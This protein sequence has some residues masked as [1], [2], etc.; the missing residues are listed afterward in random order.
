VDVAG[1]ARL[2][3]EAALV[4]LELPGLDARGGDAGPE[5]RGGNLEEHPLLLAVPDELLPGLLLQVIFQVRPLHLHELRR[6]VRA[7]VV[8][9]ELQF[10]RRRLEDHLRQ[11]RAEA[12]AHHDHVQLFRHAEPVL[13]QQRPAQ[14]EPPEPQL[15][16]R[17]LALPPA[18]HQ[19]DQDEREVIRVHAVDVHALDQ[20]PVVVQP[21]QL[22]LKLRHR[23]H[24]IAALLGVHGAPV[25]A[26]PPPQSAHGRGGGQHRDDPPAREQRSALNIHSSDKAREGACVYANAN[27]TTALPKT[28]PPQLPQCSSSS[29]TKNDGFTPSRYEITFLLFSNNQI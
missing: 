25:D 29:G 11:F 28:R 16:V 19:F 9:L 8:D 2:L 17:P 4:E 6:L 7:L 20:A 12:P 26:P 15:R 5:L 14:P 10:L 3:R 27:R 22:R 1:D 13:A 21:V 23:G 24:R 18:L